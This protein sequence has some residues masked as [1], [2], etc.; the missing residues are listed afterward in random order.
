MTSLG[1]AVSLIAIAL[2]VAP[3]SNP[4][5]MSGPADRGI[6]LAGGKPAYPP[7]AFANRG[8]TCFN[9]HSLSQGTGGGR[10][11]PPRR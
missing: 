8:Q 3:V 6:E 5:G 2:M 4:I 1:R 10:R 11:P 7:C 9:G